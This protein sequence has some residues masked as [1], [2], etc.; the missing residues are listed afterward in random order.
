MFSHDARKQPFVGRTS[1]SPLSVLGLSIDRSRAASR[2]SPHW[3]LSHDPQK[4]FRRPA[5]RSRIS[6]R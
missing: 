5:Y 4:S 3:S 2:P 6:F 1:A